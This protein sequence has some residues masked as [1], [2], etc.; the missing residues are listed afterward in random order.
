MVYV[1]DN[2][3]D[4]IVSLNGVPRNGIHVLLMRYFMLKAANLQTAL[5]YPSIIHMWQGKTLTIDMVHTY[6]HTYNM[7]HMMIDGGMVHRV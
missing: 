2:G 5:V 1:Y 3:C 4:V 6:I 7:R